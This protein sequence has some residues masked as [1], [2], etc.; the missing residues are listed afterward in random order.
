MVEEQSACLVVRDYSGQQPYV[1]FEDEPGTAISSQ[2]VDA[3]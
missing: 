3:R 1:Y 2:A